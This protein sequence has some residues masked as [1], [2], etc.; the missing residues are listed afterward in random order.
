V[1]PEKEGGWITALWRENGS[2]GLLGAKN[3]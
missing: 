1:D 2:E 3:G